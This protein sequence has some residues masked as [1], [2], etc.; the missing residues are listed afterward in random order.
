MGRFVTFCFLR[1]R[2]GGL[3]KREDDD[4]GD[5]GKKRW[6]GGMRFMSLIDI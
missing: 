5:D 4:D 6:E 1:V 2:L 3:G